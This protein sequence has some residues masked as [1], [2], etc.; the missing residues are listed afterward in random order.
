ME[1]NKFMTEK[2]DSLHIGRAFTAAINAD[3]LITEDAFRTMLMIAG[4]M[5][6]PAPTAV[7]PNN[8]P[9]YYNWDR[10]KDDVIENRNGVAIIP[11]SGP[12]FRYASLFTYYCGATSVDRL[13]RNLNAALN[14]P[15]VSSIMFEINS[16]GGEVTGISEF[17]EMV[18]RARSQK[19][20]TARV[21]GMGCS[22][23]YWIASMCGD[24]AID[25]TAILGSIGVMAVYL[26]DTKQLE[27]RGLEEIE[28]ISTQSPYKNASPSSDEGRNR[29]QKR[30]DAI[31]D[32]F[33]RAVAVGR[34]VSVQTVLDNFGQGDVFVGQ[35]AVDAGLADRVASFSSTIEALASTH[36]VGYVAGEE[37]EEFPD[38][39]EDAPT[40]DPEGSDGEDEATA[41]IN[42]SSAVNFS[43]V[44]SGSELAEHFQENGDLMKDQDKVETA[45]A[46]AQ[47]PT[48]G[49]PAGAEAKADEG[50]AAVETPDAK[51][52]DAAETAAQLKAANDRIAALEAEAHEK[53]LN[54]TVKDM[55]GE[56][57]VNKSVLSTLAEAHGK[58]SEEVK[59]FI[60]NQTALGKQIE[61]AGLFAEHGK[62]GAGTDNSAEA[63]VEAKARELMAKDST[64]TIQQARTTVYEQNP[65]LYAA[66]QEGK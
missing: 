1:T 53:W 37:Y 64:L 52:G 14:D 12:I 63:Q 59:A 44:D 55:G 27:M 10:R 11:I 21:G 54:E 31:A 26:D 46:D 49:A 47:E 16:P 41:T 60:T 8:Q 5:E 51:S 43:T 17:S 9:D 13:A 29:I 3:W 50:K 42:N 39:I 18:Y 66:I 36:T 57:T 34:G 20:I 48:A 2:N 40:E 22:A 32:V 38:P 35:A 23:A 24:I 45:V 30:I 19:P 56:D 65:D 25:K 62:K 7:D 4:R 33:V 28:F 61:T 58:D 15:Q 6:L